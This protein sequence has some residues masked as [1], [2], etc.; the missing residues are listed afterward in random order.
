MGIL[1]SSKDLDAA[2][3]KVLTELVS[4]SGCDAAGIRLQDGED[5]PYFCQTGFSDEFLWTENFLI[6]RNPDGKINRNPNGTAKLECF[7]GMVLSGRTIPDNPLFTNYGSVWTNDARE[8]LKIPKSQDP[9][10]NPRNV[11]VHRFYRSLALVPIKVKSDVIGLLQLNSKKIGLFS[12][13]AVQQLEKIA[14]H[15]G[16]AIHRQEEEHI[17]R[18]ALSQSQVATAAKSQFMANM[19]HEMR[20]PLNGIIGVT[21]LL[22]DSSLTEEQKQFISVINRS[23]AQI[24]RIVDDILNAAKTTVGEVKIINEPIGIKTLIHNTLN[25]LMIKAEE[26]NV[27]F[28]VEIDQAIP[29]ILLG[30]SSHIS[31][32]LKH[33]AD[34]AVKF[35]EKGEISVN[36]SILK[37]DD[38]YMHLKFVI[39]DSGIGIPPDKIK[40]I[41]EPFSQADNSDT[42]QYG[43]AGLGLTISRQMADIM[44]GKLEIKST[45]G[46]GTTCTFTIP[47]LLPPS[48]GTQ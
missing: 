31:L 5:F 35:T 3:N 44:G 4:V 24:L 19:S 39:K 28:K 48:E 16:I 21:E 47:M 6:S 1:N 14:A 43:G 10:H 15:I 9:R 33:L 42:R 8:A 46:K 30:D 32:I 40:H 2:L 41:F 11:C 29:D 23:G 36:C 27:D 34:N 18:D 20:T 7:C 38:K 25:Q 13:I 37:Q 17:L 45:Q 22:N 12:E 26:K